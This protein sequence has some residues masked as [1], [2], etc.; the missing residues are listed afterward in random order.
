M[1]LSLKECGPFA[2]AKNGRHQVKIDIIG[3]LHWSNDGK[4][5]HVDYMDAKLVCV[6][7]LLIIGLTDEN[8]YKL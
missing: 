8:V 7:V 2:Y 1:M 5:V 3:R 4:V 6:S